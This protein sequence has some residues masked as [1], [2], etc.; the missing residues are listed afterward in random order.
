MLGERLPDHVRKW[1]VS[2]L[3][4]PGNFLTPH[5]LATEKKQPARVMKPTDTGE[6][7]SGRLNNANR[8][9]G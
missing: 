8:K 1:I 2:E 9:T 6:D 4:K 3:E 7:Q 5:G